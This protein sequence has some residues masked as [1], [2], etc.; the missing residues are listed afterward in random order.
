MESGETFCAHIKQKG[1]LLARP[2]GRNQKNVFKS[3]RQC[4]P[5]TL[6][7]QIGLSILIGQLSWPEFS[8]GSCPVWFDQIE[9][10]VVSEM[11]GLG[12]LGS[13][14]CEDKRWEPPEQQGAT[15]GLQMVVRRALR[16]GTRIQICMM[17]IRERNSKTI[18]GLRSSWTME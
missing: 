7:V 2:L 6:K 1:A 12:H 11:S 17:Q 3:I 9:S 14:S 4:H 16:G 13:R 18:S 5:A 10:A 15:C 8:I